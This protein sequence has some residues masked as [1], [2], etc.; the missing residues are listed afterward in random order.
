MAADVVI[1]MKFLQSRETKEAVYATEATD[2]MR[3]VFLPKSQIDYVKCD[4]G[5]YT[6]TMPRWLAR[7][8]KLI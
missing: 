7:D 2:G 1:G 3:F 6:V 5:T 8:K 4:D